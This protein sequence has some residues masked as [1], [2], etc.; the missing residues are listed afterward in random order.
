MCLAY[1]LPPPSFSFVKLLFIFY[2]TCEMI[3]GIEKIVQSHVPFTVSPTM[4]YIT[5][6]VTR[7]DSL[8]GPLE[9]A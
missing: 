7:D 3:E 4:S 8:L 6:I 5:R 2:S 9:E 1:R